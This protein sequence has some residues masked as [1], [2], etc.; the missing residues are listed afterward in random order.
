[1]RLLAATVTVINAAV[2][3]V[4]WRWERSGRGVELR[5]RV[6]P[7]PLIGR[8]GDVAQMVPFAYPLLVAV[9]PGW[10]YE[11]WLN[12][13]TGFDLALQGAGMVLWAAG[14]GVGLWAARAIG[15]YGAVSG[16]T[17][18]H[19]LVRTG[20]Y[21]YVR[22]PIY[23]AMIAIAVGTTFVFRSYLLLGIAA[24]STLAHSWWAS[25]EEAL[26]G[27]PEGLAEE[28]RSYAASTGR[29]LPRLRRRAR[30]PDR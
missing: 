27:S 19:R 22:H 12:W 9:A 20:P 7:L 26:L 30:G 3:A 21:R 10:F 25:A 2:L 17:V 4:W 28:Y 14:L 5:A 24:V 11:G 6:N 23:T 1:M 16:V 15:G 8:G 18:G 13:S 29:F